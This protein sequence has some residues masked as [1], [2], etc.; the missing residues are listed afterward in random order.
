MLFSYQN[1]GRKKKTLA[2]LKNVRKHITVNDIP[3]LQQVKRI[4]GFCVPSSQIVIKKTH[5][6]ISTDPVRMWLYKVWRTTDV[7]VRPSMSLWIRTRRQNKV[8]VR[9]L[10]LIYFLCGLESAGFD[11]QITVDAQITRVK[12]GT[13]SVPFG[14]DKTF[15]SRRITWYCF[16]NMLLIC[17]RISVTVTTLSVSPPC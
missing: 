17:F 15:W 7:Q 9:F 12:L 14:L 16:K 4:F 10:V 11:I 3:L 6:W 8:L 1:G 13:V 2:L 5:T